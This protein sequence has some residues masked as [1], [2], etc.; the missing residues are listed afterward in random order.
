MIFHKV[1][2]ILQCHT[3]FHIELSEAVKVWDA[4]EKIGTIFTASV[5]SWSYL[6]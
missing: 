3:M 1:R 4:Q 2:D 5:S 6:H